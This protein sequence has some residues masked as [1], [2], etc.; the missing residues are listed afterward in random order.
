V[1]LAFAVAAHLEPEVLLVDEVLA[2][3]DAQFQKKCMGKLDDVARGGRTVL[4]VSHNM[5]AVQRLCTCALVLDH[6]RAV[7]AGDPRTAVARY[8]SGGGRRRY[9]AAFVSDEPQV[10]EAD[11]LTSRGHPVEHLIVTDPISLRLRVRLPEGSAG[12]RL[13]IGVT[14]ADGTPIFTSRLD[15]VGMTLPRG[16]RDVTVTATI[17][18]DTLL[19]GEY[20]VVT[21]LWTERGAILDLQEPALSLSVGTGPSILYQ[22]DASRKGLVQVRC[23]WAIEA[24]LPERAVR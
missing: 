21:C 9:R 14:S 19:A 12:T 16:P 3:G 1:R 15:D 23:G 24:A 8:L 22:R 11:L 7:Y 6:G 20:H 10:V 5:A 13:G 2:V 18:A 17:P 4:F